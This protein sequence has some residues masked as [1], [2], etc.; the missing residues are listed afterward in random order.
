MFYFWNDCSKLEPR[1]YAHIIGVFFVPAM[2]GF[3]DL[4]SRVVN[5]RQSENFRDET[6]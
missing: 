2:T 4:S 6:V 5:D 1:C 3:C